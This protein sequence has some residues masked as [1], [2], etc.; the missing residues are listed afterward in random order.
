MVELPTMF[1]LHMT[2]ERRNMAIIYLNCS[3]ASGENPLSGYVKYLGNRRQL[4]GDV[5]LILKT[6]GKREEKYIN[7]GRY[8]LWVS[9]IIK[10]SITLTLTHLLIQPQ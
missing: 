4:P 9:P 6:T 1:P 2:Q 8:V 3:G 7:I 5:C 10:S